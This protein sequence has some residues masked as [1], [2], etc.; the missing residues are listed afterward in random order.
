[1]AHKRKEIRDKVVELLIAANTDAGTKVYGDRVK[2]LKSDEYPSIVVFCRSETAEID[3]DGPRTYA[4]FLQCVIE[5][6]ISTDLETD[7]S[8][9]DAMEALA[10][11]I[12]NV[13][14]A[15]NW[16]GLDGVLGS[17]LVRTE[18]EFATN[19]AKPLGVVQLTYEIN[20]LSN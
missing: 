8:I 7:G 9:D 6:C 12:E 1:M 20:Y 18:L 3:T 17:R 2:A 5:G 13:L 15:N 4:R 10:L 19:G 14:Y 16:L 11:E